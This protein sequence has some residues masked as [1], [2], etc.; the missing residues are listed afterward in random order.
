VSS[1]TTGVRRTSA[2]SRLRR[3][4]L[5]IAVVIAAIVVLGYAFSAF[6]TIDTNLL[7]F[8]SVDHESV[9]TRTFWTEALLFAIFGALMAAAIAHTLIVF[10]RNRPAFEPDPLRQRWRYRFQR[11]EPRLAK[12]LFIIIV[13]YLAISMGSRATGGWQTWLAW[14][15]SVSFGQ[16]DPQF[17]RD[18]SYYVFVYPLYRMVLTFLFRIVAT[19]IVVLLV[20]GFAYGAVRLRGA[21]PRM[22]K[23]FRGQISLLI[24][25]YLVLKAVAYWFDRYGLVTSN[26]GV[27]TGLGYTDVHAVLPGRIVLLV[28]AAIAAA[29]LVYNVFART[30]RLMAIGVGVMVV[31]A[32]VIG[33]AWPGIV[34]RFKE[35]PSASVL[36]TTAIAHNIAATRS[37]FGL[38]NDVTA[39]PYPAVQSLHGAALSAQVAR[40]AQIRQL[41]PNRLSPTFNFKQQVQGYYGFKSTLDIDRYP[42]NGRMTD[43]AIAVRELNLSGLPSGRNSWSNTHLVYTHGYGAVAAPTDDLPNGLPNFVEGD[44]PPKGQL[45]ITQ[46]QIY[47]GQNSPSYSIVG[48]A[49]GAAPR[50]FDRPSANGSDQPIDTTHAGGGGVPIGSALHR[51]LYA[52]KLHSASLLFSSGINS[53][54]Q[55]LTVR[56]PRSRVAA[57]APWLTLDGDVYPTIVNG[58]VLWVVDGYTT[59]NS[60]PDS[61][62]I[63][64]RSATSNTLTQGNAIVT[65]PNA[66]I[67]YMRNS[68]KA[69]VDAYTGKVTLYAW[70]PSG[71]RDPILQSWE[72]SFPGLIQP[73]RAIPSALLPHLRYPQDLFNVQ[74]SLLTSYHVTNPS[75]FYNGSDFWKIPT[76]P[77]VGATTRINS[78]GKKVTNSAPNLPSVYMSVSPDGNS[79][80]SFALSSPLVTL[81]KRGLAAF[82]SVDSQP[83]P[84]YGKLTLLQL[85][86]TAS[87]ESPSQIQNDIES[88]PGVAQ[89]LT[90]LRGGNSRVILGNLLTIPLG[91]QFL[92]IEPI[93]T[94]ATSGASF[95]ILRRVIA[96]YG[97]GAPA[98]K[99][100]L[101]AALQQ[102]LGVPVTATGP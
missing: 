54:S 25:L 19:A 75:E 82:L 90:L 80:A 81:N 87:I 60:Y 96:I 33:Y 30:A 58:R 93:Y 67:N 65:Q 22:A 20:A 66:S 51:I 91:G 98:F 45:A 62:Q 50:E 27:V 18:V 44:L 72:E 16:R 35:R 63:N 28:V 77:T 71:T 46:P 21:P 56:N 26:R 9:Y 12:W 29:I 49:P 47:Y 95:P 99:P 2:R 8:R 14:R 88:D 52:W 94:Q 40:N 38:T 83:G 59:S 31:G 34:Q 53:H 7:W 69:T 23:P 57:V 92:Y 70:D 41:D 13:A 78:L 84:G 15:H 36:E 11:V 1:S 10:H 4:L 64:L 100:T 37:A 32:V 43:V 24:A 48:A 55:L 3:R 74:R 101:S 76:D 17:H 85:P 61:Q 68:V 73:Q 89:K 39:T 79:A 97:N 6:V 102:A 42:I 5:I 86:A